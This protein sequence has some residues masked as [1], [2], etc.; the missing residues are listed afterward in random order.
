MQ[1]TCWLVSDF[2]GMEY[3]NK[4]S[5]HNRRLILLLSE[6]CKDV[7]YIY[8]CAHK[9]M[10]SRYTV[11]LCLCLCVR[12]CTPLFLGC[13][14]CS[15]VNQGAKGLQWEGHSLNSKYVSTT[16]PSSSVWQLTRH[17][18]GCS[19]RHVL[20]SEHCPNSSAGICFWALSNNVNE[21]D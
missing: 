19:Y 6:L 17:Q 16:H 14:R 18:V 7:L 20:T 9:A 1:G 12:T 15:K 3:A 13:L 21:E 11:Q 10:M 4:T 8:I 5:L 2:V